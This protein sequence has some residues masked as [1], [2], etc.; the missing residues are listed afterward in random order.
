MQVDR[1]VLVNPATS[2]ADSPWPALGPL[3][4]QVPKVSAAQKLSDIVYATP[5]VGKSVAN[6]ISASYEMGYGVYWFVSGSGLDPQGIL[7]HAGAVFCSSCGTGTCF[8]KSNTAS[9]LWS[10]QDSP[11][12]GTGMVI[13]SCLVL[14]FGS[15]KHIA[16]GASRHGLAVSPPWWTFIWRSAPFLPLFCRE[17]MLLSDALA[18][19]MCRQ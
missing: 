13:S 16:D 2:F 18:D 10:G 6:A 19:L 11:I 12:T 8:G 17:T 1:V 9:C 15:C 3:L 7:L 4:P 14:G 5:R